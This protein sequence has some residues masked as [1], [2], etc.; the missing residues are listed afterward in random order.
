M[1][2]QL[3]RFLAESSPDPWLDDLYLEGLSRENTKFHADSGQ[4]RMSDVVW[5]IPRHSGGETYLL[6]MLEFQSTIDSWMA[7]RVLVYVGLLWQHLVKEKRVLPDGRLPPVMPIV[8]YNG[9]DRWVE[10]DAL[11]KLIGLHEAS[12]LWEWQPQMRYYLIDEGGF[13]PDDLA[14]REG[15]AALLFRLENAHEPK[16]ALVLTDALLASF[17]D[18]PLF[19]PVRHLFIE[20]LRS[21]MTTLAPGTRIPEELL[22]IR[23]M[24]ATRMEAWKQKVMQEGLE[25]GRQKGWMEGRQEGERMGR[26]KGEAAFLLRLLERRFG[27]LPEWAKTRIED[28]ETVLLEEWS[29]RVLDAVSLDEVFA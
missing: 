9:D 28:A 27:E 23:N 26:Q 16:A 20:L 17:R 13:R 4:L 1:V 5:R 10:P 7:L 11:R 15:L 21:V 3:L 8:L 2:V 29:L 12:P 6:L 24:L 25:E 18:N 22:E 14:K 19:L